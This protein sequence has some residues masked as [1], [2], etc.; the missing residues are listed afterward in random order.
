M[1]LFEESKSSL[2]KQVIMI[3][4]GLDESQYEYITETSSLW[5]TILI[6]NAIKKQIKYSDVIIYFEPSCDRDQ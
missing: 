3:I 2:N 4:E 5:D 6:N 1:T